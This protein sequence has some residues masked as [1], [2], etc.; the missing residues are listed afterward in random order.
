MD[1]VDSFMLKACKCVKLGHLWRS[2]KCDALQDQDEGNGTRGNGDGFNCHFFI[3]C[4]FLMRWQDDHGNHCA[5]VSTILYY[6]IMQFLCHSINANNSNNISCSYFLTIP[7]FSGWGG[8]IVSPNITLVNIWGTSL[9]MSVMETSCILSYRLSDVSVVMAAQSVAAWLWLKPHNRLAPSPA[10]ITLCDSLC[11][12]DP[13]LLFVDLFNE[14]LLQRRS[15]DRQ[16]IV[17]TQLTA[18]DDNQLILC[19]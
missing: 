17:T 1:Q 13:H 10:S 8:G 9:W 2:F 11:A 3:E 6:I 18:L 19:S 7:S 16:S 14:F 5:T 15:D 12:T 4:V